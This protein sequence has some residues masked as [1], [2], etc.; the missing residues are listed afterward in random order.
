MASAR[1]ILSF[2]GARLQRAESVALA[3][4]FRRANNHNEAA[5]CYYALYSLP[6]AGGA[7]REPA[8]VALIDLLFV[9]C[10]V[11]NRAAGVQDVLWEPRR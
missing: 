5:R 10:R 1:Y 4:L 2:T 3:E 7:E 11:L 9:L 8:L 6:Q